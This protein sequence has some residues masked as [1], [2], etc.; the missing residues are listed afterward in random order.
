MN[1]TSRFALIQNLFTSPCFTPVVP[2][3]LLPPFISLAV[4]SWWQV[5]DIVQAA[6]RWL[7]RR[8][9]CSLFHISSRL[10]SNCAS[11]PGHFDQP[12]WTFFSHRSFSSTAFKFCNLL[13]FF[14]I[15]AGDGEEVQ[16]HH[17]HDHEYNKIWRS[18]SS[19]PHAFLD[20]IPFF[21]HIG[22]RA[23]Y[24]GFGPTL[25]GILPYAGISFYTYD[26]LK[27]LGLQQYDLI[28]GCLF[29]LN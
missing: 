8:C 26:T 20:S 6:A 4:P 1:S 17:P 22:V 10:C 21:I 15:F 25:S 19:S 9:H 11:V 18:A 28:N 7:L 23:L 29:V 13:F 3:S 14:S 2:P 12:F 27:L 16:R 24:R 5:N